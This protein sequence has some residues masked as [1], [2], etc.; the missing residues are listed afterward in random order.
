[1]PWRVVESRS[2]A[3]QVERSPREIQQRYVVWR[4]RV[5]Q[6]GPELGGGYRVHKLRGNRKGEMAARLNR[7]WRVIFTVLH[8]ELIVHAIE[9]TPHKY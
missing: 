5:E 3:K 7:Q 6:E 4:H 9:L 8:D 1:M 2:L